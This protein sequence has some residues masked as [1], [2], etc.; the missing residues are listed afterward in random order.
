MAH[1]TATDPKMAVSAMKMMLASV[2]ILQFYHEKGQL[3]NGKS[4]FFP[5]TA[6]GTRDAGYLTQAGIMPIHRNPFTAATSPLYV[7]WRTIHVFPGIIPED[8]W[9]TTLERPCCHQP[10]DSMI[11]MTPIRNPTRAKHTASKV[12]KNCP[13][14][15]RVNVRAANFEAL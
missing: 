12:V 10:T 15:N 5:M 13:L 3:S 2:F 7:D 4:K 1:I 11:K 8:D 6:T 9:M 14:A